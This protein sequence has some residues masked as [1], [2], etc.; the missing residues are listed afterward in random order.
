MPMTP[1]CIQYEGLQDLTPC[2]AEGTNTGRCML[3]ASK[4]GR[5]QGRIATLPIRHTPNAPVCSEPA[6]GLKSNFSLQ[7]P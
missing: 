7:H 4:V 1:F 2:L 6:L 5:V 3:T